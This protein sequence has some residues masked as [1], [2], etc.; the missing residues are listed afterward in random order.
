M[1]KS[2]LLYVSLFICVVLCL[3]LSTSTA[4]TN[5]S[6][7]IAWAN[8]DGTVIGDVQGTDHEYFA[9]FITNTENQKMN[10]ITFTF[11]DPQGNNVT[12]GGAYYQYPNEIPAHGSVAIDL[13]Q[14]VQNQSNNTG[15]SIIIS[16][17]GGGNVHPFMYIRMIIQDIN[18]NFLQMLVLPFS[19]P[20]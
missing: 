15:C 17:N 4:A 1:K 8:Y 14:L 11:Y 2:Q 16:W 7:S 13:T 20:N 10:N 5:K 9:L 3:P 19:N 12:K 18:N 6:V